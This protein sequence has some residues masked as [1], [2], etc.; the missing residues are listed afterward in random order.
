M[1]IKQEDYTFVEFC[2]ISTWRDLNIL[3]C[4]TINFGPVT[5]G[6]FG[7]GTTVIYE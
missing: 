7:L 2:E 5:I 4:E 1:L 6:H 3:H